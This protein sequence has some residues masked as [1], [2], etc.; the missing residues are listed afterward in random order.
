M[1]GRESARSLSTSYAARQSRIAFTQ[2]LA[3]QQLERQSFE[4]F[5]SGALLSQID[6]NNAT[7]AFNSSRVL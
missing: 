2:T 3:L 5:G 6:S 1:V 7:K 4:T